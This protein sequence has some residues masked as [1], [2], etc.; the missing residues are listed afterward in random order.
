MSDKNKNK[1]PP[2]NNDSIIGRVDNP[3]EN[4]QKE[5][6]RDDISHVDRQEGT[7]NNGTLGGNMDSGEKVNRNKNRDQ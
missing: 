3:G 2:E 7:M 5:Q 4:Y 6:N 1:K